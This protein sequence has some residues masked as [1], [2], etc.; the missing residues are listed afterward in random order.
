MTTQ[1]KPAGAR[2]MPPGSWLTLVFTTGAAL[3]LW[4]SFSLS[5]AS[6]W[7][8]QCVLTITLLL[9]LL[10][11]CSELWAA[12]AATSKTVEHFTP[13]RFGR[14]SVALAWIGIL[15]LATWMFGVTL[16]S[17]LFCSA[18][19]RWHAREAWSL[20]LAIAAGL[21]LVLWL[22]FSVLF[23]V[24]LYQGALWPAIR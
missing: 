10:Q 18:W 15:M 17:A 8:P 14:V 12:H 5:R 1:G 2:V 6:A 9:L 23:G 3:A 20:S 21:G 4:A 24:G 7:I 16:G 19:L 11:F 13:G 22:L